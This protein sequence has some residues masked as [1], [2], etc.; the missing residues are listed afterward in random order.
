MVTRQDIITEA[1][2]WLDTPWQ[3]GQGVK[4]VGCD[5]VHLP[6]RVGQALGL[7]ATTY[8]PEPYSQQWHLH[9]RREQDE[10]LLTILADFPLVAMPLAERQPADLLV[11][12]WTF[13][14]PCAH[15]G[16]L[17]PGEKVIHALCGE[18]VNR[19]VIQP[20][21]GLRKRQMAFVYRFT[22]LE[23]IP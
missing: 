14:Q 10:L 20:L 19:V 23:T 13:R 16:L 8:V 12:R 7:I 18:S 11:F 4:G 2:T 9:K 22:A 3:H 21:Q 15:M 5:C 17:L 1:L 6:L